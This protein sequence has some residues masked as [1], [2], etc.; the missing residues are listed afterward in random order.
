MTDLKEV[1]T[2]PPEVLFVY[3]KILFFYWAML[4]LQQIYVDLIEIR[5]SVQ[6]RLMMIIYLYGTLLY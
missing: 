2:E 6:V 3:L 5:E 4:N 1:K